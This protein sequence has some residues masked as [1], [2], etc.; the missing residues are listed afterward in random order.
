M[1]SL[2]T[3]PMT[4]DTRPDSGSRFAQAQLT[5]EDR[6][7]VLETVSSTRLAEVRRARDRPF[8]RDVAMKVLHRPDAKQTSLFRFFREARIQ[9]QLDHLSVVPV[10]DR[11]SIRAARRSSA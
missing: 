9:G 11:G 3:M 10:H 7:D 5:F 4:G 1:Q 2:S 6:Y 8:A